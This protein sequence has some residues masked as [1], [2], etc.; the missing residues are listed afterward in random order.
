MPDITFLSLNDE[1]RVKEDLFGIVKILDVVYCYIRS[2][3]PR[4]DNMYVIN[5]IN[6][7]LPHPRDHAYR[8]MLSASGYIRWPKAHCSDD[9]ARYLISQDVE[10]M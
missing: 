9:M 2:E 1:A 6:L 5:N 3:G 8:F 10:L 7:S 4:S